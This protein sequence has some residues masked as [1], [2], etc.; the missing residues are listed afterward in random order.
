MKIISLVE[1][2]AGTSDLQTA[3]GLSLYIETGKHRILMDTGPSDLLLK[4]ASAFGVDLTAV[5]TVVLSHGHYDHGGG[6]PAFSK[7]NPTAQIYIHKGAWGDFVSAHKDEEVRYI[8]LMPETAEL[9]GLHI[10][11]G[12]VRI[13]DELFL[14]D[15]IGGKRAVPSGNRDLKIRID[16]TLVPDDFSHEMCLVVSEAGKHVLLSGCA[17]HGILNIMDR[18]HEVF[19]TDPDAVI[20]GFHMMQH[21]SYSDEDIRVIIG[22]AE[23]LKAYRNTEFYTCHCTGTAPYEVMKKIMGNRL[24]YLHTGDRIVI[25]QEKKRRGSYMKMHRFFAWATVFCFVMTMVMG[26]RRK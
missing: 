23:E 9:P 2:T 11:E 26:Y 1:N 16:G 4:N 18:Y 17:H 6:L 25:Q 22:T 20:S 10:V 15:G 5:D 7:I 19:G 3:H 13:D 12:D 24:K 8:G 21:G 14:F